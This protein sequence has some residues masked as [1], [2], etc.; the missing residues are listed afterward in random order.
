MISTPCLA[1]TPRPPEPTSFEGLFAKLTSSLGEAYGLEVSF[2]QIQRYR[3]PQG[4]DT[5]ACAIGT[6]YHEQFLIAAEQVKFLPLRPA[7]SSVS[8]AQADATIA[9]ITN[10]QKR[11]AAMQDVACR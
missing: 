8:A 4:P 7:G 2:S 9:A 6:K 5:A 11:A 10:G 3:G 1:D